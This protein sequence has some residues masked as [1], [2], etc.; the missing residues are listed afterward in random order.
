VDAER[1]YRITLRCP[2]CKT[3][4]RQD[5]TAQGWVVSRAY[6]HPDGYK[7]PEGTGWG[8]GVRASLR[9]ESVRRMIEGA[10]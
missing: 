2:V 5:M 1:V 6:D 8:M 9:V 7:S 3:T 4:R 10:S